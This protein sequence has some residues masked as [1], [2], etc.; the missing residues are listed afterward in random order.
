MA[1]FHLTFGDT[2]S[3]HRRTFTAAALLLAASFTTQ[4]QGWPAKPVRVV[5]P[6]AAGG[7][8]DS[9]ARVLGTKMTADLGQQVLVDNKGGAGGTM[10]AAEVARA[11][12]DG[13]T[14]LFS[15]TGALAIFP[16]LSKVSY[17]PDKDLIP[18]AHAVTTPMAIVVSAK[19]P[20]RTLADLLAYAKANPGK[21][22]FASAG[23]ATTTQLGAELLKREA[24]ITMTH[25]PYKGAAP[26]LTDVMAGNADMMIADLPAVMSFVKGG[27]L[28]A[29]AVTWP[30]RSSALPDV[31]STAELGLTSVVASTWYGLMAPANTPPDVV[32]RVNASLNKALAQPDVVSFLKTQGVE[33][34]GGA[35]AEFGKLV[36]SDTLKWGTLAK[37]AGVRLD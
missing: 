10:G 4:A 13:Y 35:P 22:N 14:L 26:A 6:F 32:A 7:P 11:P 27:K 33:P 23:P 8:A 36:K 1:A 37:A 31:P 29:L 5:V 9:L 18:V 28:H 19:S 24:G 20:Y 2:M 12:A 3:I 21:L 16:V 17:N 34:A 25:V 30:T 15:S